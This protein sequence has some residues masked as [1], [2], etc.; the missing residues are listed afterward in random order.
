VDD[1][2]V[3]LDMRAHELKQLSPAALSE[4]QLHSGYQRALAFGLRE[5]AFEM[6]RESERRAEEEAFDPGHFE[7]LERDCRKAVREISDEEAEFDELLTRL[8]YDFAPRHPALAIAFARA[9]IAS[10]SDRLFDNEM[11]LEVIRDARVDLDLAPDGDP[12]E[13][14]FDWIEDRGRR[15]KKA[16]EENEQI[17]RLAGQLDTS[18]AALDEKKR[19]LRA[20]TCPFNCRG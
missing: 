19:A 2:N 6:L 8:A 16:Q 7:P 14:L 12:A 5:L 4:G 20:S 17:A 13:A 18:L 11:L 10:H 15:K 3:V 9:A 1:P